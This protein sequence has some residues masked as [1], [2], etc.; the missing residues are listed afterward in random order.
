MRYS[1][2]VLALPALSLAQEQIPLVDKLKGW[3]NKAQSYVETA[4]PSI[5][6]IIPE[7]VDA[8]ASKVAES[9]VYPLN[10]SNWEKVLSPS[11]AAAQKSGPEEVLVFVTGQNKTCYGLCDDANAA[12]N[13]CNRFY[14]ETRHEMR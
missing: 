3:F 9:V 12:W 5:P 10:L 14:R 13:V 1:S 7:A 11:A 6:S 8:G 2:I 4:I